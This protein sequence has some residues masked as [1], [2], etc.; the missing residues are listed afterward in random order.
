M[1]EKVVIPLWFFP[2]PSCAHHC[3]APSEA[4]GPMQDTRR[5]GQGRQAVRYPHTLA[6]S[7][8]TVAIVLPMRRPR[9]R[10]VGGPSN[11]TGGWIRLWHPSSKFHTVRGTLVDQKVKKCGHQICGHGCI[12]NGGEAP[13]FP[14]QTS[15]HQTL[16]APSGVSAVRCYCPQFT[17]KIQQFQAR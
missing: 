3:L 15:L 12:H 7:M 4:Q 10:E 6:G 13:A 11:P 9:L 16:R 14:S 8:C 2:I 17:S 1:G 5:G